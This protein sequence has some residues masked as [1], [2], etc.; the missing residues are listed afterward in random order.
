MV[1]KSQTSTGLDGAK[2]L[3]NNGI[4]YLWT[5]AGFLPSTVYPGW[6]IGILISWVITIPTFLCRI[7]IPYVHQR[8]RGPFFRTLISVCQQKKITGYRQAKATSQVMGGSDRFVRR[9]VHGTYF[10]TIYINRSKVSQ[11]LLFPSQSSC[12]LPIFYQ[13]WSIWIRSGQSESSYPGKK[14]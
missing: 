3:V 5:G 9:R 12:R 13:S 6:L 14:L 2:K 11:K 8:T 10:R 7:V 1:Q 4:I